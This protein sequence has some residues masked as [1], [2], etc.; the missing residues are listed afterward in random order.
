MFLSIML[1]FSLTKNAQSQSK[2]VGGE[3]PEQ[4]LGKQKKSVFKQAKAVLNE[5]V[6]EYL[7]A[8]TS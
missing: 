4:F 8:N 7:L 1:G 2:R 5:G 6:T 3:K